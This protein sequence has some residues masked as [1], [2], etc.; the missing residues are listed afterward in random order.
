MSVSGAMRVLLLLALIASFSLCPSYGVEQDPNRFEDSEYGRKLK[1][2]MFKNRKDSKAP[3]FNTNPDLK[4]STEFKG[5][6]RFKGASELKGANTFKVANGVMGANGLKGSKGLKGASALKGLKGLK[7]SKGSPAVIPQNSVNVYF[8][9][10]AFND[11]ILFSK[12]GYAVMV[13]LYQLGGP[14]NVTVGSFYQVG[15]I[16]NKT[17]DSAGNVYVITMDRNTLLSLGPLSG[18][19]MPILGGSGMFGECPGGYATFD[20]QGTTVTFK[21]YVVQLC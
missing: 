16:Y 8:K 9:K 5:A 19:E 15:R 17:I 11:A 7:G 1:M 3:R 14:K 20:D 6:N 21:L 4:G 18:H 13:D 10:S 12:T 2:N